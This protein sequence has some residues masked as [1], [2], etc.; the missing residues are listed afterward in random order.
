MKNSEYW[1][2]RFAQLE[3][4][5]NKLAEMS[6][7]EIDRLYRQAVKEIEG[8][9]D[10]WYRR[11]AD[12]NGVSMAEARKMLSASELKE[13]KWD[14]HDYIKYGQ[15]NALN[16]QWVKQLEN[17]SAKFH[18]SKYEALKI[19]TQ[20]S[21]ESLFAKQSG[22]TSEAMKEI[23]QSG[24]YHT[25]FEIQKGFGISWDISGIDQNQLEKVITKPW[26]SDGKNFSERIWSNKQKLISEVHMLAKQVL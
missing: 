4:S 10:T 18:I 8:K 14:V 5:Q 1:K 2:L 26:A 17:A 7:S 13:F 21:L 9:I 24:Y 11:L 15:E 20:Q 19:Q 23:Y 12:N 25:A 6:R 16:G 3:E 22:I